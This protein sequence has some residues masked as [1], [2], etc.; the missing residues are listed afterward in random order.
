MI[1][2][3]TVR[4]F[5]L[6]STVF[7]YFEAIF[8]TNEPFQC[9][10]PNL[11]VLL[12]IEELCSAQR[13]EATIE[14][15]EYILRWTNFSRLCS[16]NSFVIIIFYHFIAQFYRDYIYLMLFNKIQRI[17]TWFTTISSARVKHIYPYSRNSINDQLICN[18]KHFCGI[19]HVSR[20]D[21]MIKWLESK[22]HTRK[23]KTT[24]TVYIHSFW[25]YD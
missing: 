9:N 3:K 2:V 8:I 16:E 17:N 14:P 15:L 13:I 24:F 20:Y 11:P 1:V 7:C 10:W 6:I 23:K 12:H 21:A 22:L 19:W 18:D 25:S 5:H 4:Y